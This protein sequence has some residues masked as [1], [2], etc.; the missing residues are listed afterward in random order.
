MPRLSLKRRQHES[1]TSWLSIRTCPDDAADTSGP[2]DGS[3]SSPCRPLLLPALALARPLKASC[4][5]AACWCEREAELLCCCCCSRDVR[6]PSTLPLSACCC[7]LGTLLCCVAATSGLL[8]LLLLL[9][10]GGGALPGAANPAPVLLLSVSRNLQAATLHR[11]S[12]VPNACEEGSGPN[13]LLACRIQAHL[14]GM[15]GS[16]MA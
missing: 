16:I 13:I 11:A 12:C 6:T 14:H 8:L 3:G 4:A 9:A 10:G 2:Q 15:S 5:A 1:N 7:E